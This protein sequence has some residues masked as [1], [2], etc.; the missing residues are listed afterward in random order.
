[1][2]TKTIICC[3]RCRKELP[4]GKKYVDTKQIDVCD[5]FDSVLSLDLCLPCFED[6]NRFIQ[7]LDVTAT[8]PR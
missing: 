1:M 3:D 5:N 2:S 6:F 7:N 4:G 8:L